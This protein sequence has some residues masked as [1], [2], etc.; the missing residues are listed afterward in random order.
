[1]PSVEDHPETPP[2]PDDMEAPIPGEPADKH[3]FEELAAKIAAAEAALNE[4]QREK[5]EEHEPESKIQW[6]RD[7][8]Q[9]ELQRQADGDVGLY[10]EDGTVVLDG[11]VNLYELAE[12]IRKD[13]TERL[14]QPMDEALQ[15]LA[16][17]NVRAEKE[18]DHG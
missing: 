3:K 6:L 9:D 10:F 15:R 13:L 4:R 2:F 7:A 14:S 8:I 5:T 11:T 18:H 16:M 17:V 12:A 1:M